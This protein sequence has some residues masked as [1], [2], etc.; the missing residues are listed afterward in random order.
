MGAKLFQS[1]EAVE[2][3]NHAIENEHRVLV[4]VGEKHGIRPCR[5]N[6]DDVPSGDQRPLDVRAC[7]L[8]ILQEQQLHRPGPSS[9]RTDAYGVNARSPRKLG[10]PNVRLRSGGCKGA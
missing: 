10:I 2:S 5:A 8:V 7:R 3:G 4:A 6:V 1:R 9:M